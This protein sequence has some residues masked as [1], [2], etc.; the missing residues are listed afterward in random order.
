M[1]KTNPICSVAGCCNPVLVKVR[2]L[3]AAHNR[4]WYRYGSPT[5]CGPLQPHAPAGAPR[6]FL[7]SALVTSSRDCLVWPF[8]TD[9]DGYGVV[10]VDG[11][12]RNAHR[13]VCKM[14]HGPA[15]TDK[16]EAAHDNAGR[17]CSS[18]ACINPHH[19][20]WAT[21]IE[22]EQDKRRHALAA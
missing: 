12:L 18:K 17:P 8:A 2:M 20:R 22:N 19:L 1:A 13:E 16:H 5:G 10:K 15:P 7:E 11:E 9:T 3:C 4:R 6:R 14:A 21:H